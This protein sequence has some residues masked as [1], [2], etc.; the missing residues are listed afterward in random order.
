MYRYYML[1]LALL[2]VKRVRIHGLHEVV[3]QAAAT[4]SFSCE[5]PPVKIGLY[6]MTCD[7]I[8]N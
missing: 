6:A 4:V 8:L 3:P 1:G 7:F 5:T 2:H